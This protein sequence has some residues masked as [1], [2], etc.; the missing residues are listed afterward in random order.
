[1]VETLSAALQPTD[2]VI[3]GGNVN[4]L[5][6][7]PPNTRAG[8]NHNAYTGGF[9]LWEEGGPINRRS[10]HETDSRDTASHRRV[11]GSMVNP[12]TTIENTTTT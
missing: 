5:K 8:D 2:L 3:G 12:C 11:S 9:R 4:K 10:D 1:M 6:N 7:L